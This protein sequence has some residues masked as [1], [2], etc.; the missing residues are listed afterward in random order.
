MSLNKSY[1]QGKEKLNILKGI[2]IDINTGELVALVGASGSGKST[3]LSLIAGLDQCD[4]G[5]IAINN[6]SITKLNKKE[7]TRFRAE[8]IGIVFQQ[9]YLISHL[10]AYENLEVP[11]SILGKIANPKLIEQTLASVGLGHRKSHK[12]TELSGG[13]CQRLAIARALITEPSL[14]LADEPSGNLDTETGDKVMTLFFD[15]VRKTNT[16]TLLITHDLD[17][18]KRCDRILYLRH[19]VLQ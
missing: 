19:G 13:E 3:L 9:F 15:Q 11:L 4:D 18:A 6:Q 1:K 10:T 16:T 12:P 5:D 8:N 7:M 14:L 2:N 17:L